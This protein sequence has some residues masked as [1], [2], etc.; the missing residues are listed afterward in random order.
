MSIKDRVIQEIENA[1]EPLLEKVLEL[2]TCY[3]DPVIAHLQALREQ[4]DFA[5]D[6]SDEDL[7]ESEAAYQAYVE[8]R[9]QGTSLN[10]L[11]L[12]FSEILGF[13]SLMPCH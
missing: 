6:V 12:E 7:E 1:P 9:D 4:S 13:E 8:G 2:I 3:Q 11:E 10:E 5:D